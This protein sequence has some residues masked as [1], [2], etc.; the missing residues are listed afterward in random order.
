MIAFDGTLYDGHTAAAVPV[1]LEER[2]DDIT[3]QHDFARIQPD[4]RGAGNKATQDEAPVRGVPA[5][6]G[7]GITVLRACQQ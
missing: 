4:T 1:R 5:E 2:G 7:E 3:R 6:E